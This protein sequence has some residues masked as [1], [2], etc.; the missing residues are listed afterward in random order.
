MLDIGYENMASIGLISSLPHLCAFIA[1][2]ICG[3]V[4]DS[5]RSKSS[6]G[7]NRVRRRNDFSVRR[8]RS[9]R[10]LYHIYIL[11]IHKMLIG[12]SQLGIAANLIIT[13]FFLNFTGSIVSFSMERIFLI[14]CESCLQLVLKYLTQMVT[15]KEE[16]N[17]FQRYNN[18]DLISE[19]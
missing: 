3:I 19:S 5:L 18:T 7:K 17:V 8:L 16:I 9:N 11:Q 15:E 4:N 2:P 10:Y 1:E 6:L 13:S 12:L 14:I